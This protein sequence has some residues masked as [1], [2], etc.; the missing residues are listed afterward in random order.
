MQKRTFLSPQVRRTASL[1]AG[2]GRKKLGES[3]AIIVEEDV[4]SLI[5]SNLLLHKVSGSVADPGFLEGG[6]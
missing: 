3:R 4:M 1:S 2:E 5:Q 6:F